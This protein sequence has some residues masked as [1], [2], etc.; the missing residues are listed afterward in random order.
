MARAGF[1]PE[2]TKLGGSN[3]K[4]A[5]G[6]GEII[7]AEVGLDTGGGDEL[8]C[9]MFLTFQRLDKDWNATE[10]EPVTEFLS[11]GK[12][13]FI[14]DGDEVEL[15]HPGQAKGPDDDDP[16]DLGR[17]ESAMGNCLWSGDETFM[18]D[19]RSKSAIFG[20]SLVKHGFPSDKLNGYMPNLIGIKA[21]F[22]QA[23]QQK[24]EGKEYKND[25][26]CISVKEKLIQPGKTAGKTTAAGKTAAG[27]PAASAASGKVNGKAAEGSDAGG[28]EVEGRAEEL[29]LILKKKLSSADDGVVVDRAKVSTQLLMLFPKEKIGPAVSKPIQVL[30]KNDA[31]LTQMA[32]KHGFGVDD[33]QFAFPQLEG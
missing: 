13:H 17:E 25:P 15:F 27:K 3:F 8:K 21:E 2:Q 31:W 24:Q 4:F 5:A 6:K 26:T 28:S 14:K 7:N 33:T 29:L 19:K 9:G 23:P 16:K 30:F 1:A 10:E 11:F 20:E 32:E 18:I 12:T 22:Y